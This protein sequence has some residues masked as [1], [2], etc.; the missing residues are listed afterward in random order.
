MGNCPLKG[1]FGTEASRL[2]WDIENVFLQVATYVATSFGN[3]LLE[4][5]A[6]RGHGVL[7]HSVPEAADGTKLR[8]VLLDLRSFLDEEVVTTEASSVVNGIVRWDVEL[9]QLHFLT[10]EGGGGLQIL[11]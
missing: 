3:I 4:P 7:V 2:V 10:E 1:G 6:R 8:L 9:A 5:S 11:P